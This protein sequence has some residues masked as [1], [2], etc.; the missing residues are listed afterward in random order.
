MKIIIILTFFFSLKNSYANSCIPSDNTCDFYSCTENELNCG[1]RGYPINFG[2]RFCNQFNTLK[3]KNGP[4]KRWITST[5]ICLQN[6]INKRSDSSCKLL[7][8]NSIDDHV[9][10]YYDH[11]FC[12]LNKKDKDFIKDQILKNFWVA[13]TYILK[14]AKAMLQHGC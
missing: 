4:L 6:R 9:R 10:C 5:R 3:L 1:K 7:K 11:G 12:Q 2:L 14:N 8:K 13:P